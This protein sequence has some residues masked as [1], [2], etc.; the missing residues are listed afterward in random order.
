MIKIAGIEL[1]HHHYQSCKNSLCLSVSF[2]FS[3]AR[4]ILLLLENQEQLDFLG[5]P[6]LYQ[7]TDSQNGEDIL[8]E[9]LSGSSLSITTILNRNLLA[10]VKQTCARTQF[11]THTK[12]G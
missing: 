6:A 8:V 11:S 10:R 4:Y 2:T 7:K 5:L 12:L 3:S 9:W 1:L